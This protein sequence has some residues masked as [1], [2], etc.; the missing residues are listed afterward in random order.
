MNAALSPNAGKFPLAAI[1]P[2]PRRDFY[3]KAMRRLCLLC[4]DRAFVGSIRSGGR[5]SL[6]TTYAVRTALEAETLQLVA[7]VVRT[8]QPIV[9]DQEGWLVCLPVKDE[10]DA[11]RAVMF[12]RCSIPLLSRSDLDELIEWS[13]TVASASLRSSRYYRALTPDRRAALFRYLAAALESG[14]SLRDTLFRL[15]ETSSHRPTAA[16]CTAL[17]SDVQLGLPFSQAAARHPS[18][19][20]RLHLGILHAAEAAGRLEEALSR[21][22]RYEEEQRA[23][24]ARLRRA[25][26]IP[27]T[28]ALLTA[29]GGL[30]LAPFFTAALLC[31]LSLGR[32]LPAFRKPGALARGRFT[33]VLAL[34]LEFGVP[35]ARALEL[36]GV[37]TRMPHLGRRASQCVLSGQTLARAL[38][39]TGLFSSLHLSVLGS[40]DGGPQVCWLAALCQQELVRSLDGLRF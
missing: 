21:L 18:T 33:R 16:M 40:G 30:T 25:R 36:S 29:L 14:A 23:L 37:E 1:V 39:G 17:S 2:T 28:L 19:F 4:P 3:G 20:S 38:E 5:L 9:R 35:L 27:G 11:V 12:A 22:A 7:E 6:E 32:W 10:H 26:S 34:Q 15:A 13:Q 31:L 8:G 24:Q